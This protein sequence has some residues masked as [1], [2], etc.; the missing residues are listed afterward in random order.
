MSNVTFTTDHKWKPFVYRGDVPVDVQAEY[1]SDHE[2]GFF[3]YLGVW[4]SVGEFSR[5][6]EDV[7]EFFKLD[8]CPIEPHGI[9]GGSAFHSVLIEVSDSG[10]DY[11]VCLAKS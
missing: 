5:V 11:R 6:T 2:Y 10:D 1:T 3:K 9:T 7:R 8:G 4:Y